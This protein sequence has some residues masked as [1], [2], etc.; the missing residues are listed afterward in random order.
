MVS[1]T[2][3]TSPQ[4][5]SVHPL[6]N[7]LV[8]CTRRQ[9]GTRRAASQRPLMDEHSGTN[10][11]FRVLS[12]VQYCS[13]ADNAL[14]RARWLSRHPTSEG[15]LN[16]T[17]PSVVRVPVGNIGRGMAYLADV[18]RISIALH[19]GNCQLSRGDSLKSGIFERVQAGCRRRVGIVIRAQRKG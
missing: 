18:L 11:Y 7:P 16:S 8:A 19:R 5:C 10:H 14:R 1:T 12:H 9:I 15:T 2:Q 6:Y 3:C 17:A 13:R 4:T